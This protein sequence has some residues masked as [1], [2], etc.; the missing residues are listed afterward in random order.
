[1]RDA[2]EAVPVAGSVVR[3][4]DVLSRRR[5]GQPG[6]VRPRGRHADGRGPRP[7]VVRRLGDRHAGLEPLEP[8][9]EHRPLCI[10]HDLRVV[11]P[12]LDRLADTD[13]PVGSP[14]PSAVGGNA[15]DDRWARAG[16]TPG[17]SGVSG[18]KAVDVWS[19]WVGGDRRFPIV[20]ADL[21]HPLGRPTG[22]RDRT[23]RTGSPVRACSAGRVDGFQTRPRLVGRLALLV[24]EGVALSLLVALLV[25]ALGPARVRGADR[26]RRR[27][28]TG[29]DD[30]DDR[31]DR[32]DRED[33]D[34]DPDP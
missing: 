8:R 17:R 22:V 13:E 23:R 7:A 31:D 33:G 21:P 27:A 1:M 20:R 11:L 19:R 29:D 25:A 9:G 2:D 18:R 32:E 4:E 14:R 3:D 10:D 30:R 24:G 34:E 15:Q 26:G 16:R 6:L 28:V 12:V 5:N